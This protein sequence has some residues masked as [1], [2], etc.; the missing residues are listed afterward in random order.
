MMS[1]RA[2]VESPDTE[3]L[4][5]MIDF[6]AERLVELEVT[7]LPDAHCGDRSPTRSHSVPAI[8]SGPGPRAGTVAPRIPKS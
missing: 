5:E 6:A 7:G 4:R 1:L 2:L 8:A 3:L